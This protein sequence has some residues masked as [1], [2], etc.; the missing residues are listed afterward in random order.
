M[1]VLPIEVFLI[2]FVL[3]INRERKSLE[4]FHP[5]VAKNEIIIEAVCSIKKFFLEN[6]MTN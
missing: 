4:H 6:C 3:I 2:L 1:H 5:E